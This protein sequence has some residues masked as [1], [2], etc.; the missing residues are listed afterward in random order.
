M[1]TVREGRESR[2]EGKREGESM[3]AESRIFVSLLTVGPESQ[4]IYQINAHT[5]H[6]E[7]IG[8]RQ[9]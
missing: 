9:W 2:E 5:I 4:F 6:G 3:I 8:W 1:S 7:R